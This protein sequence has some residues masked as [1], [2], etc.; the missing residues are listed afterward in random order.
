[1]T[2]LLYIQGSP[3]GERSRSGA[4]ADAFLATLAAARA[5]LN[6][7]TFNVWEEHLPPFDGRIVEGRYKLLNGL[8]VDPDQEAGWR[9][10]SATADHF[11]SF[12][13]YVLATPMWNYGLPY[14]L[15]HYIDALTHPGLTF[16]FTPEGGVA[17][18]VQGRPIL[19]VCS[20]ALPYAADSGLEHLDFQ[21]RYLAEWLGFIGF[22]NPQFITVNPMFGPPEVVEPALAAAVAAAKAAAPS[23]LG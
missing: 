9:A 3:R 22:A 19:C 6:V 8:A 4:V 14:R 11:K 5:D 20:S 21:T 16:G 17:G 15:K 7:E 23:F 13:A 12:D 18:L 10:V 1:M 2:R